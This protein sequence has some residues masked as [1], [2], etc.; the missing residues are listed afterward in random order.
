[1]QWSDIS[2]APPSRTLRQFAGLWLCFLGLAAGVQGVFRH[3]FVLM[4]VFATLALVIGLPGLFKPSIVRPVYVGSMI[5]AFPIGWTVNKII[6]ACMFYGIFTPM[7]LLFRMIGRD[8]LARRRKPAAETY[9]S[10]KSQSSNP[11]S[12]LRPF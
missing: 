3:N 8:S 9:W 5:L 12:Y 7:A 6:L 10:V 2:F 11:S 1:M 4:A